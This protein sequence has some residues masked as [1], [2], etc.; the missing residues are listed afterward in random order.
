VLIK[1]ASVAILLAVARRLPVLL[2]IGCATV[3]AA[4]IW[5]VW[6]LAS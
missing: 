2:P 1:V 4:V 6:E 3:A 5:N